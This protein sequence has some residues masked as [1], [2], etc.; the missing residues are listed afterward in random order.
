MAENKTDIDIGT[1]QIVTFRL[2]AEELALPI[3]SVQEI[4]KLPEIT[5]VPNTPSY[6]EGI[7]NLRGSIL[8]IVNLRKKLGLVAK[9]SDDKTRVV[10]LNVGGI[11]TG[12]I[13]D[14][15]S[16]VMHVEKNTLEKPPTTVS[17]VEGQYLRS[18]A[19]I[20]NGKRL[21]LILSEDQVLPELAK[22]IKAAAA[23]ATNGDQSKEK[24]AMESNMIHRQEETEQVVTFKVA[25][26]GYALDIMRVKEIIRVTEITPVPKA[27]NYIVG[28]MSL[29]N[30]LLPIMDLRV[31]FDQKNLKEEMGQEI[32]QQKLDNQRIIVVDIDGVLTGIQVDSVSHVLTLEK[33][34]IEPPPVIVSNEQ[35]SR[36]RGVGKLDNGKRLLMLLNEDGLISHLEKQQMLDAVGVDGKEQE[37]MEKVKD[38]RSDEMQLVCFKVDREEYA[39]N[40]MKV[41]EI[42]RLNEITSVP[43]TKDYIKGIINLR[44]TVVPVVDVRTRFELN[45]LED[46]EQCRIVV[47]NIEG[48]ITGL[49]VDS[50]SEVLRVSKSQI[51]TP[52]ASVSNV[53]GEFIDG[54]GKLSNG[55]RIIIL[56]NADRILAD[57]DIHEELKAS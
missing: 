53:D 51:E 16:E 27:P 11:S 7:G 8:P 40:I 12:F 5:H 26:E 34:S 10:V 2:A 55:K 38:N 23:A 30:Q 1:D 43:K 42:I 17:G 19:K 24:S 48:K 46:K 4:I 28:V 32:S 33:K 39:I 25:N 20:D 29:R 49:I 22:I 6:I 9:D 15:V 3:N 56:I 50:V 13:V 41:Q 31:L 44:G 35:S 54:V 14:S 18:I 45:S 57:V 47:V 36:I 52:P 37:K 21:V